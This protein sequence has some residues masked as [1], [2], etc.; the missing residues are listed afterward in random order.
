MNP[1][2]VYLAVDDTE[3]ALQMMPVAL[4]HDVVPSAVMAALMA[5]TTTSS[6]NFQ[7]LAVDFSMGLRELGV[8]SSPAPGVPRLARMG[9]AVR[10]GGSRPVAGI[11]LRVQSYGKNAVRARVSEKSGGA[12]PPTFF[13][14]PPQSLES[15]ARYYCALSR[16]EASPTAAL[17]RWEA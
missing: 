3:E 17:S 15:F 14:P 10:G 12:D 1:P 13:A 8:R 4:M 6:T 5:A 11:P 9:A 16:W 2:G 7:I